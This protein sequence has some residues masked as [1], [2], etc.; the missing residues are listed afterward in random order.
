MKATV[1]FMYQS[2]PV[3]DFT[4]ENTTKEIEGAIAYWIG[5][6]PGM[7]EI[8]KILVIPDDQEKDWMYVIQ[9]KRDEEA[10]YRDKNQEE[11]EKATFER[12]KKKFSQ[13]E[14]E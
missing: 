13:Y 12:L 10:A 7:Y 9:N 5:K 3:F 1:Y 6:S 4:C 14:K 8:E 11:E 2:E